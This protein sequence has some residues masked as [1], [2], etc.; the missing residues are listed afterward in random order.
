[1]SGKAAK[2]SSKPR[3]VYDADFK[4]RAV[5]MLLDWALCRFDRGTSGLS[6]TNFLYRWRRQVVCGTAT[7]SEVLD[8]RI[9]T[10][11]LEL[12]EQQLNVIHS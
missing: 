9:H 1:M 10:L 8:D 12:Y 2:S 5:Q 3:R 7:V 11:E 6:G 4:C